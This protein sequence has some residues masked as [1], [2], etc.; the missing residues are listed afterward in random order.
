MHYVGNRELTVAELSALADALGQ[1]VPS[2]A[3]RNYQL[4]LRGT[5][6]RPDAAQP[7]IRMLDMRCIR[8]LLM[9]G[10][11]PSSWRESNVVLFSICYFHFT[12]H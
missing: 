9:P 2:S 3:G 4:W 6:L 1:Y 5:S 8:D 12:M 10:A 7:L 11:N